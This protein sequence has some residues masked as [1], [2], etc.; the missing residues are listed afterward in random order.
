MAAMTHDEALLALNDHLGQ[1]VVVSVHVE[2]GSHATTV[3]EFGGVLAHWR[4]DRIGATD[5]SDEPGGAVG[6]ELMGLYELRG[7]RGG[8]GLVL[9][10]T[11]LSEADYIPH[12]PNRGLRFSLFDEEVWLEVVWGPFTEGDAEGEES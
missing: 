8:L 11:Q 9:D 5:W 2:M 4:E 3:V 1:M 7:E 12:T 6:H 10:V